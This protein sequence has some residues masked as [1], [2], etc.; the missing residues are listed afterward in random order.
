[1]R[2][3]SWN[4][5]R[6][7]H[8]DKTADF[9]KELDA[10]IYCVYELDR[11]VKRTNGIDMFQILKDKLNMNSYYVK[12]FEEIDSIWREI[13]PWGGAGGG[14]I[15]NAIF[16]KFEIKNYK[17]VELPTNSKLEYLGKTWIPELFQPRRGKRKAQVF[18]IEESGKVLNLA[19]VHLEL[20]KSN[21]MHRK[22]Q[23]ETA[24]NNLDLDSTILCG[25]F[26]NVSGVIKSTLLNNEKYGD[27][28]RFSSFS[29]CYNEKMKKEFTKSMEVNIFTKLVNED[30]FEIYKFFVPLYIKTFKIKN[31]VLENKLNKKLESDLWKA[32]LLYKKNKRYNEDTFFITYLTY[33]LKESVNEYLIKYPNTI[34]K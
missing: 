16:S 8:P 7:Y 18:E 34:N 17:T 29:L 14:E 25:D 12:E 3:V 21:W 11:G 20:W 1:M 30:I 5:E 2:I 13:I 28:E 31:P 24:I 6:G 4:L 26:N 9:L 10:D 22:L 23:L 19:T 27:T 33:F 15:G 32:I